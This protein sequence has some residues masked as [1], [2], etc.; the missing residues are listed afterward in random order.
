[1]TGWRFYTTRP[2]TL[3]GASFAAIS[4]DHPLAKA[5]EATDPEGR[6]LCRGMPQ[7]RHQRRGDRDGGKAGAGYRRAGARI[8][9]DPDWELPVYI[10]NFIL[11]DY[12][13]GRDLRLP[14][15]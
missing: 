8:R 9:F 3:L 5:L 4:P 15:A 7:G 11:M 10:A 1:M 6:G 12:G 13:T 2:D 14:G